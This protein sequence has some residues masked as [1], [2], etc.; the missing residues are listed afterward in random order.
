MAVEEVDHVQA[1]C[2]EPDPFMGTLEQEE[3]EE[4]HIKL[5]GTEDIF[6]CDKPDD[7]LDKE[8]E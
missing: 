5:E 4:A 2:V 8:G 3:E 1:E 6:T 7:W